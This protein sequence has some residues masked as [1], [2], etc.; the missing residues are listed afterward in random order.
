MKTSRRKIEELLWVVGLHDFARKVYHTTS[1]KA[2]KYHLATMHAFYGRLITPGALVFDVGANVGKFSEVLV[3]LGARVVAIEPNPDLVRHI[4]LSVTGGSI[5]V[6]Q[7]A[8]GRCCELAVL[9]V[10]DEKDDMSSMSDEWMAAMRS[11]HKEYETLWGRDITVPMTTLDCLAKRYG[12]PDY[13]K[14][15]VEGFEESVLEG[16][17]AQPALLSFEFNTAFLDATMRC[18][19]KKVFAPGS[20]FNFVVGQPDRFEME[21]WISKDELKRQLRTRGTEDRPGDIFVKRVAE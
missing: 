7:A 13:V 11:H 16:L 15:D 12:E 6:I 14:I 5:E 9:R 10:S 21:Q 20:V 8:V 1:G 3:S 2:I 19:D 18:L 4:Q 17:S